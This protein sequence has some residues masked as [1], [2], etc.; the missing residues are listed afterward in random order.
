MDIDITVVHPEFGEIT[1]KIHLNEQETLAVLQGESDPIS[2]LQGLVDI[3]VET[4]SSIGG[5]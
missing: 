4:S 2:W 5:N 1:G 3:A